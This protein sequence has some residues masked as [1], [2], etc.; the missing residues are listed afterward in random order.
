[1]QLPIELD[2]SHLFTG[3]EL[4]PGSQFRI[5]ADNRSARRKVE[6][7]VVERSGVNLGIQADDEEEGLVPR[8][9]LEVVGTSNPSLSP[10]LLSRNRGLS[11]AA[12]DVS[13]R[14]ARQ[15]TIEWSP[16]QFLTTD[17]VS[18]EELVA[19]WNSIA[20]TETEGFVLSAGVECFSST[21]SIRACTTP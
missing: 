8:L 20:L 15:R 12:I 19:M 14:R 5:S 7:T 17:S 6:Y 1:M 4:G 21:R 2:V 9:V 10:L 3:H 18:G 13:T 11:A 16:A